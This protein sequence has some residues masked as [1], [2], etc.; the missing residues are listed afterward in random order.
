MFSTK[1]LNAQ[2]NNLDAPN[3]EY[4]A[5]KYFTEYLVTIVASGHPRG[6]RQN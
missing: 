2:F 3:Y 6:W 4:L 1:D 5:L